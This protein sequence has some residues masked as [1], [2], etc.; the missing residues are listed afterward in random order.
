MVM[1]PYARGTDP[2][3]RQSVFTEEE[4]VRRKCRPTF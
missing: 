2:W 3:N 1:K 4:G